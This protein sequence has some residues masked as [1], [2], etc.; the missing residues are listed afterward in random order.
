[1]FTKENLADAIRSEMNRRILTIDELAELSGMSRSTITRI[2]NPQKV[3]CVKYDSLITIL[4]ALEIRLNTPSINHDA[5]HIKYNYLYIDNTDT[6]EYPLIT[7]SQFLIYMPLILQNLHLFSDVI[8]RIQG[9]FSCSSDSYE[10]EQLKRLFLSFDDGP[11]KQYADFLCSRIHHDYCFENDFKYAEDSEL[12]TKG[13]KDYTET[14]LRFFQVSN[15][16]QSYV[17]NILFSSQN[18]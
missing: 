10:L 12:M 11:I 16:L 17:D 6:V 18:T 9:S 7:L 14:L 4:E 5:R 13:Y 2:L 8:W 3:K 15:D 1:M